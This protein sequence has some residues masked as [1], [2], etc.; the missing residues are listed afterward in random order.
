[1]LSSFGNYYNFN[2]IVSFKDSLF[3]DAHHLNQNGVTLFNEKFIEV[4]KNDNI[5]D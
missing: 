5:I 1:M 4:L 2:K 3:F